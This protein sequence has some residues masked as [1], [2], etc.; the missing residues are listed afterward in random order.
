MPATEVTAFYAQSWINQD[1]GAARRVIAPD[2]EIA[3][4]LGQPVDDEELLDVL[5]RVAAFVDSVAIVSSTCTGDRAA[6]LYDCAGPF[7]TVRL[8]EFLT[9]TDGLLSDIRQVWDVVAVRRYFPGLLD[10]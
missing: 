3:W 6:L 5:H 7:G 9:V 1:S 2:A 8:A 10:S 4:N